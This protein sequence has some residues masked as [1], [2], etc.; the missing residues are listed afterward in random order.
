MSG[1]IIYYTN[2]KVEEPLFSFVQAQI[3]NSGLP[4]VSCSLKPIE[5][6]YNIVFNGESGPVTMVR[7]ILL[8]LENSVSDYV[9]F[10]EH[11][12]IYHPSHFEFI[13]PR[14]DTF[15]YNTNVWRVNPDNGKAITYDHL[16][17]L[18][19]LCVYLPL[20]LEHY[21]KRLQI[22][23]D[24]GYDT[25]PGNN[26][27][28]ARRMGYEPGKTKRN[29]G[30]SDD[31][32]EEWHSQFPNLDIRHRNTLTPIKMTLNSFKH[33]PT[34]WMESTVEKLYGENHSFTYRWIK[35]YQY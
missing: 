9:F 2:N 29:G 12:V 28:W 24:K 33:K 31:L 19:G 3:T 8:A 26:P 25:E 23:L 32:V 4:I 21:R 1:G 20:A 17:S 16:R 5:L 22:I 14:K 6:D 35:Y 10:C 11:D 13:P 7:Q 30:I 27:S 34:G 18:S 15:Y